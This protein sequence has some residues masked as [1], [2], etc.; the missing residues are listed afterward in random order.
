MIRLD[1]DRVRRLASVG[2]LVEPLRL[3]FATGVVAPPRSHYSLK[4]GRDAPTL[5]V[6]PSWRENGATGVKLVTVFPDNPARGLPSITGEYLLFSG[7]DGRTLT[8]IDGAALTALRTAAVS[9]LAADVLAPSVVSTFLMVGSGALAP[10]LIEGH[11]SVRDYEAVTLW[12]R[13]P[14]KAHALAADMSKR[15]VYVQVVENLADAVE[16]ADVISCATTASAPLIHGAWLKTGTHLDLV[17]GFLPTMRES[18]D[19]CM[20]GAFV[21][22]DTLDAAK[23]CGDLIGPL[24]SGLIDLDQITPLTSLVRSGSRVEPC[25]RTVFKSVGYALADLAAAEH[26]FSLAS[27]AGDRRHAEVSP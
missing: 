19:A 14:K 16:R 17:G 23:E 22:V 20:A 8:L 18:D 9:A 27:Q 26:F 15:G 24:K 5:L 21:S 10:Y 6:M 11:T 13:N 1:A 7:E 2:D 12:A 4:V 3:A 25:R